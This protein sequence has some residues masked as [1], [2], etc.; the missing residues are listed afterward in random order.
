LYKDKGK[1]KKGQIG[2]FNAMDFKS[3]PANPAPI[4]FNSIQFNSIW[5][6]LIRSLLGGVRNV[7]RN[8]LFVLGLLWD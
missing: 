2:E 5:V 7:V 1:P 4:Q 3:P 8:L 6:L